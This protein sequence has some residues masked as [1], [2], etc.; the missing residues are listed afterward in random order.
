MPQDCSDFRWRGSEGALAAESEHFLAPKKK[1]TLPPL[2]EQ[3][4][5]GTTKPTSS[6]PDMLYGHLT[7]FSLLVPN[8]DY[9][10]CS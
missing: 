1:K 7:L 2:V 10:E 3:T 5:S 8:I 9:S 4:A 6:T